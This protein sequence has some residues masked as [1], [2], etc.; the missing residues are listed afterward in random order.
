MFWDV[1]RVESVIEKAMIYVF[2]GLVEA[3]SKSKHDI[4]ML[5][6]DTYINDLNAIYI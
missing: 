1:M 3:P 4:A 6:S 5:E 2:Q